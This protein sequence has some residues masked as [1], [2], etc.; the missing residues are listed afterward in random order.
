MGVPHQVSD[1]I[2][3]EI[4]IHYNHACGGTRSTLISHVCERTYFC[5]PQGQWD[6]RHECLNA[7]GAVVPQVDEFEFQ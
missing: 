5:H 3:C 2:A 6:A 4:T 7:V 1:H